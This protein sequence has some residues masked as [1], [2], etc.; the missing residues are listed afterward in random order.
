MAAPI[1]IV[2]LDGL[3]SP[4]QASQLFTPLLSTLLP[5]TLP[6]LLPAL[7]MPTWL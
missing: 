2:R 6:P 3:Y 1:K 4:L 5:L 7:A